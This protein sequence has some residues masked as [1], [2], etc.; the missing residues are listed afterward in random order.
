ML[1]VH[2]HGDSILGI[3]FLGLYFGYFRLASLLLRLPGIAPR[4]VAYG[5]HSIRVDGNDVWA[6]YNAVCCH[7][8]STVEQISAD[9]CGPVSAWAGLGGPKSG[10]VDLCR[11]VSACVGLRWPE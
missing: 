5:M 3:L 8:P 7:A 4:G 1:R 11:L 10:W 2:P 9:R 6:V